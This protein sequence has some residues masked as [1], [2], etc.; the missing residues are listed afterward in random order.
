MH[1][2]TGRVL[3]VGSTTLDF[4]WISWR[5]VY[6]ERWQYHPCTVYTSNTTLK[7]VP[8]CVYFCKSIAY[9]TVDVEPFDNGM[10]LLLEVNRRRFDCGR[11][12]VLVVGVFDVNNNVVN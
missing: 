7:E 11:A 10:G 2:Y 9:F 4:V 8:K 3:Q 1:H 5:H 6:P 12:Y